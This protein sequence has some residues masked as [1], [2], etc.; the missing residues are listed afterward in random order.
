MASQVVKSVDV[1]KCVR[2]VV[3]SPP[4][5]TLRVG[6]RLTT[7]SPPR[8]SK[9]AQVPPWEV[10]TKD[11]PIRI[12]KDHVGTS[13]LLNTVFVNGPVICIV[14]LI[15]VVGAGEPGEY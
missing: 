14:A 6:T 13:I 11:I 8:L 15:S 3:R 12:T 1:T 2:V 10:T 4:N 5:I 9:I 7:G